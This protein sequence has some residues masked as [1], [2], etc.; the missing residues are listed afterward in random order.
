[1]WESLLLT[2]QLCFVVSINWLE[3]RKIVVPPMVCFPSCTSDGTWAFVIV[4]IQSSVT[5]F[6]V[7][8][9]CK[10]H[11]NWLSKSLHFCSAKWTILGHCETLNQLC[12]SWHLMLIPWDLLG[13]SYLTMSIQIPCTIVNDN[14]YNLLSVLPF[15]PSTSWAKSCIKCDTFFLLEIA[16]FHLQMFLLVGLTTRTA[17]STV[18]QS[19]CSPQWLCLRIWRLFSLP[20]I[21]FSTGYQIGDDLRG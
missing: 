12:H 9:T 7:L 14:T 1:M 21:N 17:T 13:L 16:T 4:G 18:I 15:R 5:C 8:L 20:H 3:R 11:V 6:H 19:T 2:M 10:Q